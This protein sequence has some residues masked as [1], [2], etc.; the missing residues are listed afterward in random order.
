MTP[1]E[2]T[3]EDAMAATDEGWDI[4]ECSGS[5]NGP[6]QIQSFD[7][8]EEWPGWDEG[9]PYPFDGDA[10][11]WV[12]V[13]TR[14]RGGSPLHQRALTFLAEHNPTEIQTIT[15]WMVGKGGQI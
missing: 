4:F 6:W 14:A 9:K 15:R 8:P 7:C 13:W 2:W 12:Y 11:A 3:R 1:D 10:D 5:E